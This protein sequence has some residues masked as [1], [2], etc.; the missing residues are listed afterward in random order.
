MGLAQ[1]KLAHLLIDAVSAVSGRLVI[2]RGGFFCYGNDGLTGVGM[3]FIES[4]LVVGSPARRHL[5]FLICRRVPYAAGWFE[6][7]ELFAGVARVRRLRVF[8]HEPIEGLL[9]VGALARLEI[10]T[11]ELHQNSVHRQRAPANDH[12]DAEDAEDQPNA[13]FQIQP[14]LQPER[15]DDVGIDLL[16]V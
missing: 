15:G 10:D 13:L 7:L 4:G 16:R 11:S 9:R 6:I 2:D 12:R 14:I 1:N 3:V 5:R 8:L